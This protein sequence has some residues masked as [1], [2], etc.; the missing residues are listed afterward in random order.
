LALTALVVASGCCTTP[1]KKQ[2]HLP[3]EGTMPRELSKTIL[4]EYTIEPPDILMVDQ[5]YL[6]PREDYRLRPRDVVRVTVR[7]GPGDTLKE[8]DLLSVEVQGVPLKT[9]SFELRPG[10]VLQIHASGIV[11]E[12]IMDVFQLDDSGEIRLRVPEVTE[13]RDMAGNVTGT[14]LADVHDYGAVNVM[15]KSVEQAEQAIQEHLHE[16]FPE[17]TVVAI[18][19]QEPLIPIQSAFVV[20]HGPDGEDAVNLPPPFGRVPLTGMTVAEAEQAITDRVQTSLYQVTV[21]AALVNTTPIN[22]SYWV[23]LDGSIDLDNPV[24]F[25]RTAGEGVVA[26]QGATTFYNVESGPLPQQ[27]PLGGLIPGGEQEVGPQPQ[28][29]GEAQKTVLYR[30]VEGIRDLTRP[31]A[32]RR[33]K[34]HLADHFLDA[35]VLVSI[36]QVAAQQQILGQH[37]VTPDGT[38]TLGTYGSVCVV[39]MTLSQAKAAVESYLAQ[40]FQTPEISVDVYAYNS[41]VY[42]IITQGA[43]L[44]DSIIRLPITGNETVLDAISQ[45]GGMGYASSKR[46]WIARPTPQP[47]QVQILPVEWEEITA[48]ASPETNY[49]LLPGDRLFIAEDKLVAFDV[50]L[51]KLLAPVYSI[52]RFATITTSTVSRFSGNILQTGRQGF[53]THTG[54]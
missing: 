49:Q 40:Y 20:H 39:G 26:G 3:M 34:E 8:G 46:I 13:V 4:P 43:G 5:V 19:V 18:L 41:K 30:R 44:G 50:G 22:A 14:E 28:Q 29:A 42:Y 1:E 10:D 45:I 38:V 47:E 27:P 48:Q 51:E 25:A 31:E 16:R 17:A 53:R 36:E 6:V 12:P 21:R 37:L 35:E 33:I 9:R 2:L 23:E 15:G 52:Y 11:P 54:Y 7:R 24:Q 32:E